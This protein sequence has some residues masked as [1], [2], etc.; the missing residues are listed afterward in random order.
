MMRAFRGYSALRRELAEYPWAT[1]WRKLRS[2][3]QG[4]SGRW[5]AQI[6]DLLIAAVIAGIAAARGAGGTATVVPEVQSEEGS[7][8]ATEER[9]PSRTGRLLGRWLDPERAPREGGAYRT[10]TGMIWRRPE[11]QRREESASVS[12]WFQPWLGGRRPLA[13]IPL[14]AVAIIV[15]IAGMTALI[16]ILPA[17]AAHGTHPPRVTREP[18]SHVVRTGVPVNFTAWANGLPRPAVKWQVSVRGERFVDVPGA[19]SRTLGVEAKASD[20]GNRYRA[21][22]SNVSGAA[23]TGAAALIVTKP[24]ALGVAVFDPIY[25]KTGNQFQRYQSVVERPPRILEWYQS[26]P[27]ST[28]N[29]SRFPLYLGNEKQLVRRK[30]LT[31]LISWSTG[32]ISLKRIV[33]GATNGENTAALA[34]AVAL[35]RS[36]PGT[37]YIRLDWEMN[38]SWSQWNPGNAAQARQGETPATFVAMWQHVVNYFRAA[39]VT[40]V[41]WVWAPNVDAGDGAMSA[42]YP[43]D[44]YVDYV[45]LDGYNYAYTQGGPWQ[46]PEQVF[47]ASYAELERITHKPVI[48]AETSSVEA[49]SSEAAEGFTK[50]LWIQQLSAYLPTLSNVVAVCWFDQPAL[51]T[52][53]GRVNFS[54][55]SSSAAL[56]AWDKY[57]V[58]NPEYQGKLLP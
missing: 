52:G 31:P 30:N 9:S 44:R 3:L 46:T 24:L 19:T 16:G 50:A 7:A 55:N 22:F 32:G 11:I 29:G 56:G 37:L 38:G 48:I 39:G 27:T 28:A 5:S 26:W 53:Y 43:G 40:N 20:D 2:C 1:S 49:D 34:R 41:K 51:V 45:G 35:A 57:F 36:Y 23:V 25:P 12:E 58:N 33:D 18:S 6:W 13:S 42:Y 47:G 14:R 4:G 15:T 54:V 17:D 21:I 8:G 10:V